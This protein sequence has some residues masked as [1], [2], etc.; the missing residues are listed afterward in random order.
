MSNNFDV[1]VIGSGYGGAVTACRLA[2]KGLRVLILERGRRW[3]AQTFPRRLFDP[4]RY[5]RDN[6]EK[7][8][9]WLDLNLISDANMTVVSGAGVGGGSLLSANVSTIPPAHVFAAGWPPEITYE[10]LLPYFTQ[11]GH[12]LRVRTIPENQLTRR[13]QLVSE[14][15]EKMGF[16][17]RL[18]PLEL[19]VSFDES[20][21]VNARPYRDEQSVYQ[22]NPQGLTQGT[23]VHSGNCMIGCQVNAKNTLDLNYLASAQQNGAEIRPLHLV[24]QIKAESPGYQV[25][26]DEIRDGRLIAGSETAERVIVAAG[27]LG[28]TE[29]LLRSR[30]E[31]K[32][33]PNVSPTLGQRWS[34]NGNYFTPAVYPNRPISPSEGPTST[35]QIDFTDGMLG[36]R[37]SIED[38]GMPEVIAQWAT[39]GMP[40]V[41]QDVLGEAVRLDG[42]PDHVMPWFSNGVNSANGQLSLKP[43]WLRKRWKLNLKWDMEKSKHLFDEIANMHLKLTGSTGGQSTITPVLKYFN[44]LIALQP[45]GGCNMGQSASDGVVDHRGEVF[46]HKNLYVVDGAIVPEAIGI[47]PSRTIAALAERIASLMT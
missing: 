39:E 32:T 2:E 29:L 11:V 6:P 34:A 7:S 3:T 15:A 31:H 13:S 33:L 9:G 38:G 26:Y 42:G 8:N 21:D 14:A 20:F 19:A 40:Q 37:F 44:L 23:C 27:S 24:R 12:M 5:D 35:Y 18:R 36:Q 16:S 30:D 17:S 4:W 45:L 43:A 10:E 25:F 1:I 47:H 41:Y 46:G 28:S 22:L